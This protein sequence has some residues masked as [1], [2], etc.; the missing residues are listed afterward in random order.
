MVKIFVGVHSTSDHSIV[1]QEGVS[2]WGSA[3][4]NVWDVS[5]LMGL[6]Q[7]SAVMVS[8]RP[9]LIALAV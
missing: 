2:R 8:H 6:S 9:R 5:G 3:S 4:L 1:I 7:K